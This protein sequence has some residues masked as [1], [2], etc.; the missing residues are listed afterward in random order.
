MTHAP[1]LELPLQP[2]GDTGAFPSLSDYVA[3]RLRDA[4]LSGAIPANALLRQE[5][6]GQR[7]GVSRPPVREALKRLESE[8]LAVSRPRRGYVVTSIALSEIE[9][10][11][12]IR[13]LLEERAAHIAA[14]HRTTAD[15]AVL[16][17]TL[18]TMEALP[19]G[20]VE[21]AVAFVQ[22]NR[23]FHDR[24]HQVSGRRQ[25]AGIMVAL[26]NKVERFIRVG[27]M[28]ANSRAMVNQEHRAIFG[29][30]K[31]G[32]AERL[33]LLC[34]RHVQDAGVR[35]VRVL[36]AKGEESEVTCATGISKE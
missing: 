36:R 8:G 20:T 26:R 10:I 29:A 9:E 12:E 30:F 35:L 2:A 25:M 34:R 3:S 1:Y 22:H 17:E 21:G 16:E 32:D 31:D 18:A 6:V 4:I 24:I 7:F 15:V 33:S 28:I 27:S 11:F 13:A 23:H 14:Q 5:D 19:A